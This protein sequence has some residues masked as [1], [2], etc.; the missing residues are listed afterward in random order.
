MKSLKTIFVTMTIAVCCGLVLAACP[1]PAGPDTPAPKP[2]TAAVPVIE[3]QPVSATYS[4]NA[5]TVAALSVGVTAADAGELSFQWYSNTANSNEGGTFIPGTDSAEYTPPVTALGTKYYYVVVTNTLTVN[6]KTATAQAVSNAAAI[7]VNNL[8]NA[9][10][11]VITVQ[12]QNKSYVKD[13]PVTVPLAVTAEVSDGGELSYQWYS[14]S[15]NF[16]SGGALISG[17]TGATYT[18]P[19]TV[20]GTIY[21][22]VIVTNTI[23]DNGDGGDKDHETV[24]NAVSVQVDDKV[25]AAAPSISGHPASAVYNKDDTPVTD[26]SVTAAASDGGELTYQWYSNTSNSNSGGISIGGAD[27]ASYTPPV[28][29]PGIVYYYVVVTNTITDNGDGGAKTASVTSNT[30]KITVT[31]IARPVVHFLVNEAGSGF[32]NAGTGGATYTASPDGGSFE[33]TAS[34]LKVFNSGGVLSGTTTARDWGGSWNNYTGIGSVDLG[35]A[36]GDLVGTLSNWTIETYICMPANGQVDRIGQFVWGFSDQQSPTN[37]VWF[38]HRHFQLMIKVNGTDDNMGIYAG[39]PEAGDNEWNAVSPLHQLGKWHQLVTTQNGTTVTTYLDGYQIFQS[40]AGNST[41]SIGTGKLTQNRLGK[42]LYGET[43]PN[44]SLFN[45]KYYSFSIYDEALDSAAVSALFNAGPIGQGKLGTEP[46]AAVAPIITTQPE[47]VTFGTTGAASALTVTAFNDGGSLSYQWY[48]NGAASNSGGTLISG[49][50]GA[51]FTPPAAAGVTYYYVVVTNTIANNGDG[52]AKTASVSSNAVAAT[53]RVNAVVPA[54]AVQ[55]AGANY[56][57]STGPVSDLSVTASVT[58][59][60]SLSYQWFSNSSSST[61]GA[62][63]IDSATGASYT[64]PIDTLGTAYYYVVITNTITDNSDGG[65]K[66]AAVTSGIVAIRVD[67]KVNA[68]AP[69]I[70]AQPAGAMY[71]QNAGTVSALSVTATVSDDGS[72][73]YQWYRNSTS[74]TGGALAIDSANGSTYTPPVTALGTTYYYVQVTNTI[75]DNGD[76]GDKAVE[77]L[78]GIVPVFVEFPYNPEGAVVSFRVNSAGT[79]FASRGSGGET[80]SPQAVG[81]SFVTQGGI[82]LFNTG[83]TVNGQDE[84]P[85]ATGNYWPHYENIGYVDLGAATGDYLVGLANYTIETYI[86]MPTD[87]QVDRIGQFVWGFSDQ[88][89][90]TNAVWFGHRHFALMTKVSG[91][92]SNI[93][94]GDWGTVSAKHQQ[95]TWRHMVV[96]RSGNGVKVYLDKVLFNSGTANQSHTSIAQ[97]TLTQNYLGKSLYGEGVYDQSLFK[98]K[99]YAFNIYNTAKTLEEIEALYDTGP[100]GQTVLTT[101]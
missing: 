62:A 90:P 55:P 88:Q 10:I 86:C 64:P 27:A 75:S 6:G 30:A 45:T 18:P 37:A 77:I 82:R 87:G 73:S 74:S 17:A 31:D 63:A 40:L 23:S 36:S 48:S 61:E 51:S 19:V 93:E 96:T 39:T 29:A 38:G 3:T 12:P 47:A 52:G 81:G 83:G 92:D 101:Y 95:G 42:S 32:T 25:N 11:P 67:D 80:Y 28:T 16:N 58:D 97:G 68:V 2:L 99:F 98:T 56:I 5:A 71:Q 69:V 26:I 60:G 14:N 54:I 59:G 20:L 35:A 13:A 8:V 70:S 41:A 53:V 49:A 66:T 15:S 24:S 22:Y 89:A 91:S 33:T 100:I 46:V 85:W 7:T 9:A 50:N 44:Q 72:L 79:A 76:G 84:I 43:G 57:Q 78:S 65:V 1:S 34:G 4:Q 94:V 21:Y